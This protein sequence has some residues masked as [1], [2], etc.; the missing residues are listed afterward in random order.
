MSNLYS[1][2]QAYWHRADDS[3]QDRGQLELDWQ[4][5]YDRILR[6]LDAQDLGEVL[7]NDAGV[8]LVLA[9]ACKDDNDVVM[10]RTIGKSVVDALR[11]Y[12]K[13]QAD[14]S[15]FGKVMK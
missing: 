11:A 12:A 15:I 4:S 13:R 2:S 1:E 10:H 6:E 14:I 7:Y 8:I 9:R 5:E 3:G